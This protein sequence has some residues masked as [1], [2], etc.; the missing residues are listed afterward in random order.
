MLER[1]IRI[2]G[3]GLLHN[4]D[5]KQFACRKATLIYAENGRGKSTLA[6]ILRS[7][8]S[9][10]ASL[11]SDRQTV[12]GDLPP[13]VLLQFGSG[14]KVSFNDGVWSEQRPEVLV[15][16]TDFVERNVYSGGVVNTTHRKNLLG[17]A[18]GEPAVEAR[19]FL[20]KKTGE[21]Q[22][23]SLKVGAL[24]DQLSGYHAGLTLAQFEKLAQV[25]DI[26]VKIEVLQK[27]IDAANNVALIQAK[28]VPAQIPLPSFDIDGFF[29]VLNTS[30]KDVHADA[31]QTVR[32]HVE[33]LGN[34]V[35]EGWVSQGQQFDNSEKCPY[36]G[37]NT[38]D[39]DLIQAYQTHFNAAYNELKSKVSQACKTAETG[40][41]QNVVE[42]FSQNVIAAATYAAT[43]ADYVQVPQIQFN[44]DAAI[45]SLNKLRGL[46]LEL[47][48]RKQASPAEQLGNAAEKKQITALWQQVI[49]PMLPANITI[50]AASEIINT[51]KGALAADNIPQMQH[52]MSQIQATKRRYEPKVVELVDD[53][54]EARADS[55][56]AEKAKSTARESLN[57][58][59]K[60]TLDKYERTIN[61]FLRYFG[62]SF[63]IKGMG[64]NFRGAAPR[65]EYG[66]LLRGKDVALEGG[67]PS[68]STTLSE[69]DKRTL[70]LAFFVASTVADPKLDSRIVV[71]DDPMSSLDL[72]RKQYTRTVLRNI[73]SKAGQLILLAHDPYFLRDFRDAIRKDDKG[74]Q[75][76]TFQLAYVAEGYT[77]FAKFDV[78]KECES[79]YFRHH[80]QLNEFIAGLVDDTRSVAKGVRPLLEGYLHRRF[81][82]LL[83]KDLMLGGVINLIRDAVPPSPLLHARGLVE[84]LKEINNY[85]GQF[86][87]DTNDSADTVNVMA[88][89]LK[90]YVER[91]LLVIHKS[92]V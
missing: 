20:E 51:Y 92:T 84:E 81:P 65:S 23:A 5:G 47:C 39:N 16:D 17:F 32:K 69:G 82:G 25:D 40:T 31:E 67:S 59:M 14:H 66:L 13:N 57:V 21:A 38:V 64:A 27:R 53:L 74:V 49:A 1:I 62:A 63:S 19:T 58:L 48:Q 87:H 83:P 54:I 3:V 8:S 10:D 90:V 73:Y 60:A 11:I 34:K 41:V 24:A 85:A 55:T 18:L 22:K 29:T 28:P 37:Q 6:T 80:R 91:A 36:C 30:L 9:G 46:V 89:E 86:H 4:A 42:G 68:F 76:A 52:Q 56:A 35:A 71:I 26:D 7:V 44:T 75:I 33:Y 78:D 88:A 43:W 12:D 15:F 77:D 79:P 50:N 2:Q 61:V 45:E 72:N 70:A